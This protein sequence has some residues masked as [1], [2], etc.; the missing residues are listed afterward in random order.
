MT[1]FGG[2]SRETQRRLEIAAEWRVRI[3]DDPSLQ[4]ADD[5]VNWIA[6]PAN[7][8]AYGAVE[9]GWGSVGDFGTSPEL[10]SMRRT[11]LAR[12]YGAGV[13]QWFP[14]SLGRIAAVLLV[15]VLA[16]AGTLFYVATS[17]T[18]Y[19]TEIGERRLVSLPDGSRISLDSNSEVRVDYTDQARSL[20]LTHGRARFDVAHD[21]TR[22]FTVT[23]GA[24]TVVALGT[25]FNVE[26]L[27]NRVLV[28]LIKGQVVVKSAL[29]LT[30]PDKSQ[31]A[32]PV[33][34]TA[35]QVLVAARNAK[36]TV[37]AANLQAETAWEAGQLVFKNET[38]A[39]AVERVNRYTDRP[40]IVDPSVSTIRITGVFNAGDVTSFVSGVTSYFP[41]Q[42]TTTTEHRIVLQRRS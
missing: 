11:A 6:D 38:L 8:A 28:T 41:V 21:V 9:E 34:L 36:P 12:A 24:E 3:H 30:S 40:V 1:S 17:A 31:L 35:G 33:S 18:V 22:P 32:G 10:L 16:G 26:R 42:A 2:L 13:R 27:A 23:A 5:F 19:A 29:P 4:F 37:A 20:E 39:E 7:S 25:S 15:A 14:R